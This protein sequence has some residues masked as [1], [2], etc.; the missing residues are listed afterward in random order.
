MRVWGAAPGE[1]PTA[2]IPAY[3]EDY[4]FLIHGLLR[5]HSATHD[6]RWLR[7]AKSLT[8]QMVK[9]HFDETGGGFYATAHDHEKLFARAKDQF[10]GAQPSGNSMSAWILV[11]LAKATGEKRYLEL[12]HRTLQA[13]GNTLTDH[14]G[15]LPMMAV[16]LDEY[17]ALGDASTK[18]E[19]PAAKG[20]RSDSV[21]K[22]T[23][24]ADKPNAENE[25]TVVVTFTID[26]GYHIYANPVGQEKL[27][28]SQTNVTVASRANPLVAKLTY[29]P[30]KVVKDETVGDYQIYEGEVVVKV[31]VKR[32]AG[33][34]TPLEVSATFMACTDKTCLLPASVKLTVP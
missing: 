20:L 2:R 29:P 4:A 33:D 13:F 8:D 31:A 3:L 32:A 28:D 15:G 21:V 18:S 1:E 6:D 10:D 24:K 26:K 25:Q 16:A 17:L 34:A 5:L 22:V 12:A 14:P 27:T 9:W 7:E 19:P 23:A 11:R 30:G